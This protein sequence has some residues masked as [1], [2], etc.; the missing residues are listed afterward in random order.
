MDIH[1]AI[2][3]QLLYVLRMPGNK[4]KFARGHPL[5][6]YAKSSEKLTFLT[7]WYAH[8]RVRIKGLEMSAFRKILRTYLMDDPLR[9]LLVN[10]TAKKNNHHKQQHQ[11]PQ[12]N[13]HKGF[14]FYCSKIRQ[15][16]SRNG[17]ECLYIS[18]VNVTLSK[19]Q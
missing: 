17:Q 15:P 18:L 4:R 14:S 5:S 7:P 11:Q 13:H 3:F 12:H 9:L 8:V 10:H 16:I 1:P 19:S 2:I 6:R